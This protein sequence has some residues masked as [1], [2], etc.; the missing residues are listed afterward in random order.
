M[1]KKEFIAKYGQQ[2]SMVVFKKWRHVKEFLVLAEVFGIT[3]L[4]GQCA[5]QGITKMEYLNVL[6]K[7]GIGAKFS[8]KVRCGFDGHFKLTYCSTHTT[9][10][11]SYKRVEYT[12]LFK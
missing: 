5:T 3:W 12:S 7:A 6:R 8:V 1:T 9:P 10:F 2:S 4:E 11:Q